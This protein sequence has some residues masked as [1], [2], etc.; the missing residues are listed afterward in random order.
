MTHC[1]STSLESELLYN[2]RFTAG[3]FDLATSPLRVT[4]SNCIFELSTY[5]YSPY[6]SFTIAAGHCQRSHSQVL[7]P[8]DSV[9]AFYCL[10]LETPN[11]EGQVP[12]FISPRNRAAQ[13]Y[14][15]ARSSFFVAPLRLSVL[16]WRYSTP[17]PHG[18]HLVAYTVVLITSRHGLYR[19]HRSQEYPACLPLRCLEMGVLYCWLRMCWN[20]FT[21][22]LP[23]NG[24]V[25]Y[26]TFTTL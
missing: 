9:T 13:L 24:S 1:D 17:P 4:T 3:Q 22:S 11:L 2:W 8:R 21:D 19:K 14:P 10:R 18:K 16:R 12:V 20:V 7:V 5:G 6:L 15:Q 26:S 25:L 23:S